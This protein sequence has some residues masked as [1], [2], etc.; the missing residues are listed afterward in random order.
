[1]TFATLPAKIHA[2]AYDSGASYHLVN[3]SLEGASFD[4]QLGAR[5]VCDWSTEEATN[6]TFRQDP[7][8]QNSMGHVKINFH[9]PHA[10]YLHDTPQQGLFAE[11]ARFHSS[12]CVRVANVAEF[13][14]WVLRDSGY[15][16][17]VCVSL[18]ITKMREQPSFTVGEEIYMIGEL[19]K[20]ILSGN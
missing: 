1:M 12:G 7:G 4:T 20:I 2:A 10:V 8:A 19:T 6:Y 16:I 9:N 18:F 15:D 13:V 5:F 11:N 17:N 3:G 14:A